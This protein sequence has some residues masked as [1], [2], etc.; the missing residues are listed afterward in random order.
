MFTSRIW[1]CQGWA[2]TCLD[3]TAWLIGFLLE[4]FK[5]LIQ[6]P[7]MKK[8][9]SPQIKL[10]MIFVS[11]SRSQQAS[12]L[13][14]RKDVVSCGYYMLLGRFGTNSILLRNIDWFHFPFGSGPR[15]QLTDWTSSPKISVNMHIV[16]CCLIIRPDYVEA[17]GLDGQ[18]FMFQKFKTTDSPDWFRTDPIIQKLFFDYLFLSSSMFCG[19]DHETMSVSKNQ[20]NILFLKYHGES[21]RKFQEQV[22]IC[23]FPYTIQPS[24]CQ[25]DPLIGVSKHCL[26]QHKWDG[27]APFINVSWIH[28]DAQKRDEKDGENG[29]RSEIGWSC[30]GTDGNPSWVESDLRVRKSWWL[31]CGVFVSKINCFR[32]LHPNVS[33]VKSVLIYIEHVFFRSISR[34]PFALFWLRHL[35]PKVQ[36]SKRESFFR[37]LR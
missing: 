2:S 35:S 26:C 18:I 32:I 33:F 17:H 21:F 30:F 5:M 11:R 4:T 6:P 20:P 7:H 37:G 9:C 15:H 1:R 10:N 25:G 16:Y 13:L 22:S 28:S 29:Q 24:P 19:C 3:K 23:F 12:S 14:W 31:M 36:L 34:C 8:G 27:P